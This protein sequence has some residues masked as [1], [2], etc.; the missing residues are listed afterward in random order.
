[1]KIPQPGDRVVLIV[2]D[3]P[4]IRELLRIK[5]ATLF[6]VFL[7]AENG[8]EGLFLLERGPA[9]LLVISDIRMPV[10]DGLSFIS[11]ARARGHLQPFVVFTAYAT[12]EALNQAIRHGVHGF[13]EKGSLRGLEEVVQCAL[14]A[15]SGDGP[16]DL[17]RELENLP[18]ADN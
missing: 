18:G 4:L 13:V 11:E 9:P 12:R 10:M 3:E 1:M 15:V 8:Q 14:Q 2:D 16:M 5:L 17:L 6:D 7:E